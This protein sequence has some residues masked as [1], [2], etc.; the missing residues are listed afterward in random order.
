MSDLSSR[1]VDPDLEQG[2]GPVIAYATHYVRHE[3]I[4]CQECMARNGQETP[5]PR[6]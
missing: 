6:A 5:E 2:V 3:F 4:G 1:R